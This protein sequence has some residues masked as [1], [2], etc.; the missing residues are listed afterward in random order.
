MSENSNQNLVKASRYRAS[1]VATLTSGWGDLERPVGPA[2]GQ[3]APVGH[4]QG[5]HSYK[6]GPIATK[7]GVRMRGT[8]DSRLVKRA[9]ESHKMRL[10]CGGL[11]I[12]KG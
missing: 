11:I 3:T 6:S 9:G 7:L 10:S 4:L 12:Q 8:R 5:R 2:I 1:N